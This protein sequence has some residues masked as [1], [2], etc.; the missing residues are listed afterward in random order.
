MLRSLLVVS[1]VGLLAV[2]TV[3]AAHGG[4]RS[5]RLSAVDREPPE[6]RARPSDEALAERRAAVAA[7]PRERAARFA[8]VRGLMAAGRLA[9]ALAAARDWRAVDA[10]DLV[11]VRL[12]GDILTELGRVDEARRVYSAVVELLPRDA[13]AQRALATVLKQGGLLDAAYERLAVATALRP[14]DGRLA[15]E[16]ADAAQRL[17]RAEE[18]ETRLRAVVA[19]ERLP[20]EL[21]VPAAQRLA[22]ALAARRRTLAAAGDA[23]GAARLQADV[24]ALA[25]KGG[26]VNDI[27]VFLTWD[28]DGSDVDL[29]VV[30]P[31]GETVKYDHKE[32]RFGEALLHD[33]TTG[34]GPESF[35]ARSAHPGTWVVK[36]NYYGTGNAAFSEARGEVVVLLHE[37]TAAEERHVL[38]Y[39]L[40]AAGQTVEVARIDVR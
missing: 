1:V 16:L 9:D 35:T 19:D 32:G 25:V 2:L 18:A 12:M 37:G 3:T 34:Y 24:D 20:E 21:R 8:L 31:A 28:T 33:V 29:W 26:S 22:Q 11:V 36:V 40:F 27:K 30:N 13:Q 4:E 6:G 38:P 17:G 39:R 15:F 23:A 14:E 7:A 5:L 10:Y